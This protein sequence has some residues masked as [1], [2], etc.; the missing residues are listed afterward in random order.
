MNHGLDPI[1]WAAITL[2]IIL[3]CATVGWIGW[4]CGKLQC[5]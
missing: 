3:V 2:S 1:D 5:W 4:V